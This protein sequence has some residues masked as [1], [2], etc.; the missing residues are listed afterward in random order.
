MSYGV[1]VKTDDAPT[2]LGYRTPFSICLYTTFFSSMHSR[3]QGP[4]SEG[5]KCVTDTLTHIQAKC[6]RPSALR[7]VGLENTVNSGLQ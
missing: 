6:R 3:E 1:F 2:M 7:A 4:Q 5:S